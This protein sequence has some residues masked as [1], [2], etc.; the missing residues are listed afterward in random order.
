ML[1]KRLVIAALVL[2]VVCVC[3]ISGPPLRSC[4]AATK[5]WR[6]PKNNV[7]VIKYAV[8]E[9]NNGY[10]KVIE[11]NGCFSHTMSGR[12]YL[13]KNG[14]IRASVDSGTKAFWQEVENGKSNER[15]DQICRNLGISI[16]WA[17]K[18]GLNPIVAVIEIPIVKF[19][20]WLVDRNVAAIAMY[21]K[22]DDVL[23]PYDTLA[24]YEI[25]VVARIAAEIYSTMGKRLVIPAE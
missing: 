7:F 11:T 1:W 20:D 16:Q 8:T 22:S 3:S 12:I 2:F 15:I 4:R 25:D 10:Y 5:T 14:N 13:T 21:F 24:A 23:L 19:T 9:Y 6:Y 18:I 17:V